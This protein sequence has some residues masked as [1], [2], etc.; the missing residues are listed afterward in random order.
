M[1]FQTKDYPAPDAVRIRDAATKRLGLSS[2][3]TKLQVEGLMESL[4][5]EMTREVEKAT[6]RQAAEAAV[7]DI[8]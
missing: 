7:I 2:Q 5:R 1:I 4:L 6:A 3:A 8:P